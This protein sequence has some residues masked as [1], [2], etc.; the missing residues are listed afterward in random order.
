MIGTNI[1]RRR[2]LHTGHRCMS[3]QDTHHTLSILDVHL[4]YQLMLCCMGR[5]GTGERGDGTIPQYI[6]K[7]KTTLKMAYDVIRE[8]LDVAQKK[9]KERRDKHCAEVNFKVGIEF[10]SLIQQ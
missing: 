2:C 4:F 9:R 7:V 6:K 3:P 8:I 10:G 5:F 1:C